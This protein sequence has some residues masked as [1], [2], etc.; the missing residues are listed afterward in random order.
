MWKIF[1]RAETLGHVETHALG[2][3]EAAIGDGQ[4]TGLNQF[5]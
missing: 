1:R 2:A 3:Q 4:L 5:A